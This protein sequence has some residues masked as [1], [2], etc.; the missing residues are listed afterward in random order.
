MRLLFS[1]ET[2]ILSSGEPKEA[3]PWLPCRKHRLAAGTGAGPGVIA[4][5]Y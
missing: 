3:A 4:T 2:G 5:L 1:G